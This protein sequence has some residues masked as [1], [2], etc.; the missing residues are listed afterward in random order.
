MTSSL[1]SRALVMVAQ[2]AFQAAMAVHRLMIRQ[3][4]AEGRLRMY[5]ITIRGAITPHD[6][7]M[8]AIRLGPCAQKKRRSYASRV[9]IMKKGAPYVMEVCRNKQLMTWAEYRAE[10]RGE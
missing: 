1:Y 10:R 8:P 2:P 9:M 7:W 5:H 3:A 6:L 4:I